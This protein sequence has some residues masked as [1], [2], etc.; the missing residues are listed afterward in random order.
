MAEGEA[1]TVSDLD[2]YRSARLLIDQHGDEAPIHAAVQAD[3][4]LE[5]GDLDGSAVWRRVVAV[6]KELQRSEPKPGRGGIEQHW[7]R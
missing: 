7:A 4:M 2:V 6:I 5:R 3:A 1:A